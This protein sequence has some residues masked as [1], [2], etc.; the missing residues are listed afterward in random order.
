MSQQK[1]RRLL[2]QLHDELSDDARGLDEE[3]LEL[4]RRLDRD[5]DRVIESDESPERPLMDD[6]VALEA[7][8]AVDHPVAERLI[9]ELIENLARMGI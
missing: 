1:V 9:R 4:A 2:Q 8:F 7:R 3:T 6:A 5:I